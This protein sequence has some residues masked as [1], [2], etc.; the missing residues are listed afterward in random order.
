MS[1]ADSIIIYLYSYFPA[2]TLGLFFWW[3]DRFERE[4]LGVVVFAF[5]WGAIGAGLLSFFWNTFFHVLLEVYQK[6]SFAANEVIIGVVVAPFVEELTKG[7]VILFLLRFKVVDNVTDGILMGILIGLGFAAAE[8]VFY[9]QQVVYPNDGELAMWSNLWF[10]ELHTTLLHASA[11]AV[12]GAVIGYSRQFRRSQKWLVVLVGFILAVVTHGCWNFF[13]VYVNQIQ[14]HFNLVSI[15]MRLELILI[16][17]MLISLFL[18]SLFNESQTIV[19]E[20]TEESDNHII[21]WEHVGFFASLIRFPRRYRLP[22]AIKPSQYAKL[23]VRLAFRKRDL[24]YNPA[25]G[26]LQEVIQLRVRLKELSLPEE[27]PVSQ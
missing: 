25:P 17:G 26:I 13:A 18:F 11:T 8:N 27:G 10:R 1:G 21:P 24:K 15:L 7:F 22:A 4:S 5:L 9:C 14:S 23:G 16:F 12:W 19:S 3:L 20:L 2:I 6:N